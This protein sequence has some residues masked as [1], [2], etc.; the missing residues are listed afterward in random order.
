M[1]SSPGAL[2]IVTAAKSGHV[3]HSVVIKTVPAPPFVPEP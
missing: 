1:A 2:L 3:A